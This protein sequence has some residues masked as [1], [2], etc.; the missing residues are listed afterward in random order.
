MYQ[1]NLSTISGSSLDRLVSKAR[2]LRVRSHCVK[3]N[4]TF[5]RNLYSSAHVKEYCFDFDIGL[6]WDVILK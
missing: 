2:A 1:Y 6:N 5:T 4:D 3:A